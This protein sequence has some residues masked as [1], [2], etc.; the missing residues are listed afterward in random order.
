M[1]KAF[2]LINCEPGKE[3][4]ILKQLREMKNVVDVQGTY[5]VYDIVARIESDDK[6][7]LENIISDQIR[8]LDDVNSTLTLIP[9]ESE[10]VKSD[11]REIEPDVIPEQKKPLEEQ[12]S[13]KEDNDLD[14]EPEEDYD[15]ED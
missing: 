2:V 8:K 12:S 9:T 5:G 7:Q 6:S 3:P 4:S 13:E 10:D 15:D 1:D 11:L 14:D